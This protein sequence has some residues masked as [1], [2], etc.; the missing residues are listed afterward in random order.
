MSPSIPSQLVNTLTS[1]AGP[2]N[3]IT[4]SS[5]GGTYILTGS[6][7][8]QIHLSRTEPAT[9][10]KAATGPIQKYASHG[11]PVLD[12]AVTNDNKQFASVG[13]DRSVFLWDVQNAEGT[14]RRFGSST[15]QSHTS[16]ITCV[17]FAGESD[18]VLVSG[19]DDRSVRLWDTKSKDVKPL[20]VLEEAKDNIS[21]LAVPLNSYEVVT[22]SV[23]GRVRSYDIRMGRITLDIMAAA[24]TSLA[25]SRDART[26]LV[27][28]LDSQIRL[29]D[30]SD[31]ACLKTYPGE[32]NAQGF[33]ND[34][35]RL[36][37]CFAV[38]ET[39][40][41]SGS[42]SDGKVRAWDIVSGKA[43]GP[44]EQ[45]A[46]GK[47]VS[48]VSWREGSQAEGRRG[49]LATGGAAGTVTIYGSK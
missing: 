8:R 9:A 40:V 29:I 19:S 34:S 39:M 6:S 11:Y 35:L 20:M 42:E 4:F 14:L 33:K 21:A 1:H 10:G 46:A 25:V 24:V 31:G 15:N 32:G 49:L 48:A 12:I 36:R 47:V 30:R 28:A 3:A 44:I 41:V 38:D 16:R 5:L 37:S 43:L 17:E 13:G 22:G 45:N 26:M 27:G 23:D 7:D 2:V 18:S